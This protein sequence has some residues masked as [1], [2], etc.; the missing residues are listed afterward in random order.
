MNNIPQFL[1]HLPIWNETPMSK[2]QSAPVK[3]VSEYYP[4]C[5]GDKRGGPGGGR[6]RKTPK[7]KECVVCGKTF[8]VK[9]GCTKQQTCG[10]ECGYKLASAVKRGEKL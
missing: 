2:G 6:P 10:R 1:A 3:Y 7:Y 9:N 8:E 5:R 4:T